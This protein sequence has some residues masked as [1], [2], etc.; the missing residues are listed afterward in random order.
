MFAPKA[1][2]PSTGGLNI[3]TNSANSLFGTN[4]Q[5]TSTSTPASGT[6]GSLF[7]NANSTAQ[8]KPTG[9]LFGN[10]QSTQPAGSNMFSGLG[11]PQTGAT[12]GGIFGGASTTTTTQPQSSGLFGTTGAG[13]GTST[14]QT[15]TGGLFGGGLGATAQTQ[16]KPLGLNNVASGTTGGLFGNT[17]NTQQQSQQPQ[18]PSLGLFANASTAQQPLQQSTATGNVVPGVKVDLTNLLPTT[19]YESCA[20]ELRREIENI[21]NAILEQIRMCNEVADILPTIEQQGSTIPNDVEFVQG[22]LDTIQHALENDASDIDQLRGLVTRDAAE[23]QVA[24]RAIDTLKLPMQYQSSGGG[25][26]WSVHDQ[27]VP[28]RGSLRSTRK[29]TLALPDDVE[30]DPSTANA[31]NGVPVNLVDYFSHRSDEMS[32]VLGRYKGNLKE[33]EDHLHGVEVN[34]NR[35]IHDFISS[36]SRD[37]SGAGT[38]KSA[39][40]DLAAVLGDVEAGIMGVAARLGSVT[41]QVQEVSLGPLGLGDGRM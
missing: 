10:T 25:G 31:V 15:G 11:Q 32:A 4:P 6:S 14:T 12:G 18:K 26:W 23:A 40:N 41:E 28:D 1:A 9:S 22:K 24:F 13:A 19:K 36:K 35:Q 20:D 30:V 39:V 33:I 2:A 3:N 8:S 21:D 16:Q 27:K 34:L 38:P 7:G 29:N 17:Q 5:T 37:G